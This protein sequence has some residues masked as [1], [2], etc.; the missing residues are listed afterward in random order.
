MSDEDPVTLF[1]AFKDIKI[2]VVDD[3]LTIRSLLITS[4][5]Q[6][7]FSQIEQAADGDIAL[8][9]LLKNKVNLLITDWKMPNMNGID[10]TKKVRSS[11]DL[12][13]LKILMVTTNNSKEQIAEAMQAGVNC[14]LTKPFNLKT[15]TES[16]MNIFC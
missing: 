5:H 8:D 4:L 15:L 14:Y 10:L 12:K 16:L 7:G 13:D 1:K 6:L 9:Y 11:Q 3:L 2:L